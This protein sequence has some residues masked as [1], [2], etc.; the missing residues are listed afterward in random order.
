[1]TID[2]QRALLCIAREA[3]EEV[4]SGKPSPAFARIAADPPEEV[5]GEEGA[6]VTLKQRGLSPAAAGSLRGCIGNII[7]TGPLYKLIKH[8]AGESAFHD[9]RFP[10]VRLTELSQLR[11]EISILTV[12][13]P[14]AS[15]SEIV[16]GQDGVL[17]TK[18]THRSVFLPQVA[19]EQG[20]DREEMLNHLAM[21]AGL[22][23]S[24][25]QQQSCLF[26]VFQAEIFQE[27]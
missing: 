22:Y 26:E 17:L 12:P 2:S 23:P 15:V 13:K 20:W 1:M 10:P 9:P 6:F 24:A 14:V 16:V 4:L 21:K 11:I 18:G 5:T 27:E 3:I 7:A 19:I 25:W 8:L